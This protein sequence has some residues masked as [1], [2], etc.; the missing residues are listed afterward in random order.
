MAKSCYCALQADESTDTVKL[1]SLLLFVRFELNGEACSANR[2]RFVRLGR[3]FS[4]LLKTLSKSAAWIGGSICW[5]KRRWCQSHDRCKER[6]AL[7]QAVALE[8]KLNPL[9]IHRE[10]LATQDIPADLKQ[11]LDEAVKMI[12]REG[13]LLS[14]S[15]I[16]SALRRDEQWLHAASISHWSTSVRGAYRSRNFLF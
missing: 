15:S 14:S 1:A 9:C 11:A 10:A 13:R 5:D 3:L 16:C 7:S 4:K 6:V 12:S 8:A 2:C